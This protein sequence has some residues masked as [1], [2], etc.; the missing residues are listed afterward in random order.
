MVFRSDTSFEKDD[1]FTSDVGFEMMGFDSE[2]DFEVITF[3]SDVVF[4][5]DTT[6]I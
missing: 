6:L 4:E 3:K 2:A 1:A 5:S